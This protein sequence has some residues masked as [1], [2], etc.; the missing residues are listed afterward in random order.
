MRRKIITALF[1]L[2]FVQQA[3]SLDEGTDLMNLDFNAIDNPFA[4]QKIIS[5]KDYN[6]AISKYENMKKRKSEGFWAWIFRHTLPK[7]M[8][9]VP[10]KKNENFEN[11]ELPTEFKMYNEILNRKP[12]LT[13]GNVIYDYNGKEIPQGHYQLVY[14]DGE[15]RFVQGF[16]VLGHI[17]A[18]KANDNFNTN[19]IIYARVID[20][21]SDYLK[22]FFSDSKD[23]YEG[24]ARIKHFN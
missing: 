5:D 11:N 7:E 3:F 13:L 10:E 21:N 1:L 14:K 23:C 8:Q 16:E 6:A 9:N 2:L 18:H 19:E 20:I 24:Y 12:T 4:G 17:K 22:I 15:I